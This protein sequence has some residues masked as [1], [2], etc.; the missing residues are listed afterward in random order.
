[1]K[2]T[3]TNH[4]YDLWESYYDYL[5]KM[6]F[7]TAGTGSFRRVL[8]R[9]QVVIK[10]PVDKDGYL[11]NVIEARAWHKYKSKPTDLGIPLAPCRM[12]P[13]GYGS[14]MM[15]R[16]DR[17]GRH[18]S[19]LPLWTQQGDI[20]GDQIG[21]WKDKLMAYDYALEITERLAWEREFG[22]TNSFFQRNGT[23]TRL[24]KRL[25]ELEKA[26]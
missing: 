4:I 13:N 1:M 21:L 20:G 18:P 23:Y 9:G 12:L 8:S 24:L 11:D 25:D 14:L 7:R 17:H 6:G 16:L 22:W 15:V 3:L 10:I 2:K 5:V 19:D 26:A